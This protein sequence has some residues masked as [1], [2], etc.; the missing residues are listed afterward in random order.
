MRLGSDLE[1]TCGPLGTVLGRPWALP[2]LVLEPLGAL[3]GG[4]GALLGRLGGFLGPSCGHL[5]HLKKQTAELAKSFK[6]LRKIND[7]GGSRGPRWGQDGVK[8]GHVGPSWAHV[9]LKLASS[10][11]LAGLLP[12]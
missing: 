3:L 11:E 8:L 12:S 4:L 2:G 9:G 6:N 7:F 5:G 1:A 10:G